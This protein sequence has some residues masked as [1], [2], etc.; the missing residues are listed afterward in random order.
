VITPYALGAIAAHFAYSLAVA[1]ALGRGHA[2][3][4]QVAR[5]TGWGDVVFA[6]VIALVTEGTN[7]PFYVFFA[8]ALVAVG[9]RSGL[10]RALAVTAVGVAL[11]LALLVLG[12]HGENV[13]AHIMRPAYLAVLGYLV[14]YMGEQHLRLGA[15]VREL[16]AAAQRDAIARSLHDGYNQ[17]LAGVNLRLETCRELLRRGRTE[18]TLVELDELQRGVT[19]EYDELRAYV[20]S[21]ADRTTSPAVGDQAPSTTRFVVRAE[22][23]GSGDL[24]EHVLQILREGALNVRRHA[25]ARSASIAVRTVETEV[26]VQIDDD[27]VGFG[28]GAEPPWSIASRVRE[29]AGALRLG[30]GPGAHLSI[31]L[32]QT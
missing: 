16:E 6:T 17:A 26:L 13:N 18:A 7:S 9:F 22:F 24:V 2:S 23:A 29:L 12:S 30:E 11:Y 25:R 5:I 20:R 14:G 4:V 19:R 1:F 8:F 31:A 15:K 3:P 28:E 10:R 27:G 32:P 21:L